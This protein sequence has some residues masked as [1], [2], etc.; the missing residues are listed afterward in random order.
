M[1]QQL[2]AGLERLKNEFN[3]VEEIRQK[4][5]FIGIK[6]NDPAYG[7]LMSI[8]CYHNGILA[9]YANNDTS[10]LQLLPP[11]IISEEHANY[12]LE[13]LQRAMEFASRRKDLLEMIRGLV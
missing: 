11:L 10:V 2:S 12:I 7:P 3:F 1:A 6:M 9:A 8:A 4:G 5:L 13:H